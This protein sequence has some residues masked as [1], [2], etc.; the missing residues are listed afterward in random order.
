MNRDRLPEV[1]VNRRI[2]EME[3]AVRGPIPLRAAEL[4]KMGKTIIPCNLGNPQALGQSPISFY[5]EV[6]SLVEYPVRIE[7][8]RRLNA[9]LNGGKLH[10][11]GEAD[12][13]SDD[14]LEVSENFLE[15]M[16]TGMGAYSESNGPQFIREAIAKFIDLR[17]KVQDLPGQRSRADQIFIT[18]GA[19]EAARY[20]IDLLINDEND[21]IMIPIPQYPLYSAAIKR[22]GGTQVEYFLEEEANWVVNIDSLRTSIDAARLR[23]IN[24]K[25]SLIH[26]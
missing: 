17:D 5:R 18:N 23:G 10:D 6:L 12:F 15:K 4:K 13:H 14:V 2:L 25:L 1:V 20:V 7:R 11:L 9:L 26:I 3:Y 22:C 24:V 16:E 21:G 19:S 8:E